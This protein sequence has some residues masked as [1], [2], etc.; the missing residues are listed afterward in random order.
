MIGL[1]EKW[2]IQRKPCLKNSK[3]PTQK[4]KNDLNI[5]VLATKEDSSANIEG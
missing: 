3:P 1:V 5:S 2:T 4:P